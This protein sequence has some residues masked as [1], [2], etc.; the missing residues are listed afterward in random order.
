M[1]YCWINKNGVHVAIADCNAN[2]ET[3]DAYLESS[4]SVILHLVPGDIV[5]VGDCSDIDTIYYGWQTSFSGF[6]LRED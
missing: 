1:A 4:N 2:N 6:L 5:S 3:A